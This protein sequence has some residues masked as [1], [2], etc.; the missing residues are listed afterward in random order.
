MTSKNAKDVLF[1]RRPDLG[2]I[3]LSCANTN[4]TV[5]YVDLV[6]ELLED[7]VSTDPVISGFRGEISTGVISSLLLNRLNDAGLPFTP[8]ATVSEF[9]NSSNERIV[10][11]EMVVCKLI[12]HEIHRDIWDIRIL[13]QTYGSTEQVA[14]VPQHV[15]S[16]AYDVLSQSVYAFGLPFDLAHEETRAYFTQFG[17]ARGDLMRALKIGSGPSDSEIMAEDLSLGEVE[18]TLI[19]TPDPGN[20]AKYWNS[21]NEIP[22]TF[23]KVVLRFIEKAVITYTDLQALLILQWLNPQGVLSIVHLDDSCDLDK[24]EIAGLDDLSLDRLHRFIR[25]WKRTRTPPEV[26]DRAIRATKLGKNVLA[27]H[28]LL[29]IRDMSLISAQLHLS[30]AE[31]CTFYSTIP[32]SRYSQIFLN[33]AANGK[34]E[35]VFEPSHI[36]ANEKSPARLS[37]HASYVALCLGTGEPVVL[38]IIESLGGPSVILSLENLAAVYSLCMIAKALI[39]SVQDLLTIKTISEIDPLL[40]PTSTLV[41]LDAVKKIQGANISPSKLLFLLTNNSNDATIQ[42]LT[43]EAVLG[44]LQSLQAAYTP[45]ILSNT[46]EFDDLASPIENRRALMNVLSKVEGFDPS[47][48]NWFNQMLDEISRKVGDSNQIAHELSVKLS[49]LSTTSL[50]AITAALDQALAPAAGDPDQKNFIRSLIDALSAWLT[51]QGKIQVL[52]LELQSYFGLSQAV[53]TE[54]LQYARLR[55]PTSAGNL[56]LADILTDDALDPKDLSLPSIDAVQFSTQI[57]AIRLL[58]VMARYFPSLELPAVQ[59]GWLLEN[60]PTFGWF[61]LDDLAY[62]LNIS[63]GTPGDQI[64]PISYTT[65]ASFQDLLYLLKSYIQI[66]NQANPK[67]PFTVFGLFELTKHSTTT[68]DTFISYLAQLTGLETRTLDALSGHFGF[69]LNTKPAPFWEPESYLKLQ[70]AATILRKLGLD[71]RPAL[72][73]CVNRLSVA[74]SL[75][76]REALKARYADAD[77][78]G[79]LKTVQDPIRGKK[80]DALI[81]YLL[82]VNP[83]LHTSTDLY[84]YYLIDV[85]MGPCMS[86]SRIVQAH[87][88]IQL[89]V[90]RCLLGL[91]PQIV[92]DLV[93]DNHW[94]QWKWMAN[95]RVWEA[96]RKVFLWPENWIEPSLRLDKSEIFEKFENELFESSLSDDAVESSLRTYLDDLEDIAQLDIVASHYDVYTLRMHVFARTP[97]GEPHV[98]YHRQFIQEREWTPWEKVDLDINGPQLV[99]FVRNGRLCLSWPVFSEES[100]PKQM[101]EPIKIPKSREVDSAA[102]SQSDQPKRRWK[103]QLAVSEWSDGRWKAKRVSEGALYHPKEY[104]EGVSLPPITQYTFYH[105]KS[106]SEHAIF[107]RRHLNTTSHARDNLHIGL[108]TLTGIKHYAEP[109]YDE[110]FPLLQRYFPNTYLENGRFTRYQ[111]QPHNDF[112]FQPSQDARL[113]FNSGAS[114]YKATHSLQGSSIESILSASDRLYPIFRPLWHSKLDPRIAVNVPFFFGDFLRSYVM[115]PG[116]F[117]RPG[118]TGVPQ[119]E[120]TFTDFWTHTKDVLV[121]LKKWEALLQV[122]PHL[123]D[124]EILADPEYVR[125]LGTVSS[126][127]WLH[128]AVRIRNIGHHLVPSLRDAINTGG[129]AGLMKRSTQLQ[130]SSDIQT[131]YSPNFSEVAWPWPVQD[132]DFAN[133]GANSC[134]NWEL[135]FHAP[136][137]IAIRLNQDGKFESA[138]QWFHHIFNPVGTMD[139]SA[140]PAPRWYWITKPFFLT[141]TADYINSRIDK[142]L[143]AVADPNGDLA[144]D[145]KF[146]IS[147]LRANPFQPHVIAKTRP[148]AYQLAVVIKYIRNLLDWGDALFREYTRESITQATQ[149][150]NLADKL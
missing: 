149:Y 76:M 139:S 101:Y 57:W 17:I 122:R 150:Y 7:A 138:Q 36:L 50:A 20:Q 80:R 34:V 28:T 66:E 32:D 106:G 63:N 45:I 59:I 5:P 43:I 75:V 19:T 77:W 98:Y 107:G 97:G 41:F 112:K 115:I 109:V 95:F 146:A 117:D 30:L 124:A 62:N 25:L 148:V 131:L 92:A 102:G 99:P 140:V 13:K 137:E 73:L 67:D 1:S 142:I 86:T 111:Y 52:N 129:V 27:Y 104:A 72:S 6:C 82:A 136:F 143:M 4:T 61:K 144:N 126:W 121:L 16:A 51:K 125:L 100:N 53:V 44:V 135:F 118:G 130:E 54:I 90:Q 47:T 33:S 71:L 11:D 29:H 147:Q 113:I 134:Y 85:E 49:F 110:K 40:S 2:D 68:L 132:I 42:D 8:T 12:R 26:L 48:L 116:F 46:S 55:Q 96:N 114:A 88:T 83:A 87:A 21:G 31:V 91:E 127:Q 103:I 10:R 22:A 78:L 56:P 58:S 15:N 120:V 79:V 3:D 81:A 141:Y 133:N 69:A 60:S 9:Y 108:F 84:R 14:A 93:H 128:D 145:L 119:V 37:D 65:W 70:T 24:K 23:M 74:E 18:S 94:S 64:N 38:L 105:G 35:S 39:I 89:F 123:H